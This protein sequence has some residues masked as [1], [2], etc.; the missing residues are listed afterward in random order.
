[1]KYPPIWKMIKSFFGRGVVGEGR[2]KGKK[3]EIGSQRGKAKR[4]APNVPVPD[5]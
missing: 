4:K 3:A 1:V 5:F 2:E